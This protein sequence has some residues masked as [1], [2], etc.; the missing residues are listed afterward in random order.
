M[1]STR[2]R[3]Q[4]VLIQVSVNNEPQA[5]SFFKVRDFKISERG[6]I[7]EE[8]YLG[9]VADDLDYQH[10]GFDGSFTID[11]ED[12]LALA[13]M[14]SIV[15]LE[16]ASEAHPDIVITATYVYRD[17]SITGVVEIYSDCFMRLSEQNVGG[18]KEYVQSSFEFK[19]KTRQLMAV[20]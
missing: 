3:G 16:E 4:E 9:E 5:G 13:F 17:P 11:N 14:A 7:V 15:A 8:S 19:A 2:I 6:D 12:A 20:G 18:R 10:H 1:S